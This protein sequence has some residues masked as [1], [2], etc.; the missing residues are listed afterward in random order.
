MSP[1]DRKIPKKRNQSFPQYNDADACIPNRS[2][3]AGFHKQYLRCRLRS[4][5][6]AIKILSN[7]CLGPA[8]IY[9]IPKEKKKQTKTKQDF[10]EYKFDLTKL[11]SVKNLKSKMKISFSLAV[12]ASLALLPTADGHGYMFEPSTRNYYAHSDGLVFGSAAGVP[13]KEYCQHCLNS[14]AG[15]CGISESGT[16]YDAWLDSQGNPMPWITQRTYEPGQ[17]I[18]VHSHLASVRHYTQIILSY[19]FQI[20]DFSFD[21]VAF[22]HFRTNR[23][24]QAIW[25]SGAVPTERIQP[26]SVLLSTCFISS[27]ILHTIYQQV[28]QTHRISF[29]A[30]KRS[31][32]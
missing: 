1:F 25:S 7:N 30:R 2:E 11:K 29:S 9:N 4:L 32:C 17:V 18:E 23:T 27:K 28:S 26:R 15:V 8:A 5:T 31:S 22:Y 13:E 14:N 3:L 12:F 21:P 10:C 20:A 16:D 19:Y 6:R 24:M